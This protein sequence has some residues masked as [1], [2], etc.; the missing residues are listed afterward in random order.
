LA[1]AQSIQG[2]EGIRLP[3]YPPV[4]S[5][6]VVDNYFG[7]KITDRYRW[8]EDARSADTR[9]FVEAQNAYT[10]R[11][12]RQAK[13]RPQI[14]EDLDPLERV[15]RWS[16]PEARGES[17]FFSKRLASEDQASIYVRH[18]FGGKDERLVDPAALSRDP[19][20]SVDIATVSADGNYLAYH[21]RHGGA[22]E[23]EL[24]ICD[25]RTGRTL[26]DQLPSAL[27]WSVAFRPDGKALYYTRTTDKG[28]LLYEHV[29][30][31][32]ISADTLLFGREFHGELLG[33]NE[34][35][36]ATVTDDGHYLVVQIDR[37]IPASRVDIVYKDLTH[38][39]KPFEILVWGLDARFSAIE[40]KGAWY[41]KTDYKA[42]NG[43]IYKA[44]PGIM[45]DNWMS[46]IPEG[47]EAIDDWSIVGGHI[48]LKRMADARP[49]IAVYSLAG[50]PQGQLQL[51]S[52]G[53]PSV[54]QGRA[55]DRYAWFGF[56]SFIQPPTLY[57]LDT[58]NGKRE[59]FAQPKVPFDSS[60]YEIRQLFYTSKDGTRVPIYVAG[61][62]GLKQDGT[63]RLLMSA[64]GGFAINMTPSWKADW[65]W[66]IEQGGFFAMPGLR[67]GGEYGERW[68]QQA[69]FEHKQNVFDDFY[70]AAEF[71]IAQKFT[72]PSRLA[73]TG[74]SNGGLLMGAAM[75]QRPELFGAIVCGYPL[76]DMLRY[77]HFL[78]GP[79]WI[80]E[81]GSADNEKQFPYL[82]KYS[83]YHNVK[84]GTAY[85]AIL[86]FTGESDTRVDP[87]H[88]RKMTALMQASSASGRPILLHLSAAGGHS[89]GVSVAQ[90]IEDHADQLA[91]LWTETAAAA[92][93]SAQQK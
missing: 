44:D 1:A 25:T 91:F 46:V 34:M 6:V 66:W 29:I 89:S 71:L 87:L 30:G 28:T 13:I 14:V 70:A 54:P 92:S 62:K 80:T 23:T 90:S 21:L 39:A 27:Y 2:R 65:A 51:D 83:P 85:P 73:I 42:P 50:K 16:Q 40:D 75:T 26:E 22:D 7:T 49:Q 88:A 81:Y 84:A 69:M 67:G 48:Y 72:S 19:N 61:K 74:R 41:V 57:R 9:A 64:Y 8:L 24:R 33:T 82:Q 59:I 38:P 86:F 93:P 35:F 68:H 3:A 5:K 32:R 12:F 52:I 76:L 55:T 63:A 20:T 79:H 47:P 60:Q 58:A 43:R 37:G 78:Q 4:E 31:T 56:E 10:A 15:T 17:L 53:T 18:G 36:D 77:Q 45:P 11:Y